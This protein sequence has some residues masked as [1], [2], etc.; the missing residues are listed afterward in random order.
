MA[1]KRMP[2][3]GIIGIFREFLA[4]NLAKSQYFL[5]TKFIR[6]QLLH[7]ILSESFRLIR[8]F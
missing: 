6:L 8:G 4:H 7:N 5:M 3:Y 1:K 2:I